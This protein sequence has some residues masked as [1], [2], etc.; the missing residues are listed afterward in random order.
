MK[1]V[2]AKAGEVRLSNPDRVLYAEQG[3]TKLD[4][5]EYYAAVAPVML[6][7][8]G[9]RPLT[10]VRGP[11][12]QQKKCFFQKHRVAGVSEAIKGVKI[13]ESDG[14]DEYMAIS[15]AA[16][17]LALVQ[18][19]VLEIHTW[20]SHTDQVEKPDLLV[21]DL[22][23]D[24]AVPWKF[25]VDAAHILRD[26]LSHANLESFVK[27]TGGKGLHVCVPITRR[28]TWEQAKLFS[29]LVAVNVVRDNPKRYIATM[30]K[31]KRHGKIFIDYFRNQRGATFIAPYSTRAR[32]GAPVA[33]PLAWDELSARVNPG[34]KY[35]LQ[36]V[37]KIILQRPDPWADMLHMKQ[38]ISESTL[39]KLK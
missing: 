25:V 24:E 5:A 14:T 36:S 4:L 9:K 10:L 11:Q 38:T 16:G 29:Q 34:A 8:S 39:D 15:D 12:G 26:K 13:S 17:L 1:F 27:S 3:I 22:D 18:M 21:F 28:L 20:G 2:R 31:A 30:S 32:S 35:T 33:M 19:G 37:P 7:Y 6:R 23:P